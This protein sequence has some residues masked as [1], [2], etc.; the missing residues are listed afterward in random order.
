MPS[1]LQLSV[2]LRSELCTTQHPAAQECTWAHS[3]QQ[4]LPACLLQPKAC[5]GVLPAAQ[6]GTWAR[7]MFGQLLLSWVQGRTICGPAQQI[8]WTRAYLNALLTCGH[9]LQYGM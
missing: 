1:A 2:H 7:S 3:M 8:T 4:L 9:L 5:P 6:K